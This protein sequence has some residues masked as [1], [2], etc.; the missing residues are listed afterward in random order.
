[1]AFAFVRNFVNKVRRRASQAGSARKRQHLSNQEFTAGKENRGLFPKLPFNINTLFRPMLV[2]LVILL[3]YFIAINISALM[4][5][6]TVPFPGTVKDSSSRN[7]LGDTKMTILLIGSDQTDLDHT[8][9][10]SLAIYSLDPIENKL[11]IFVVNPDLTIFQPSVGMEVNY[12]SIFNDKE[13]TGDKLKVLIN[14]VES[15]LALK[16]DRYVLIDK[17]KLA[18]FSQYLNPVKVNLSKAV[19]DADT[20]NL[21]AGKYV[22]WGKGSQTVLSSDFLEFAAS[23][24]NGRDDQLNRQQQLLEQITYN[25]V[26]FRTVFYFPKLLEE[27]KKDVYTDL[28][29][30]E[31]FFLVARITQIKSGDMLKGYTRSDFYTRV[32]TTSFYPTFSPD[33]EVMDQDLNNIF[34]DLRIF[35]E[36]A[37]VEILNASSVKGLASNR[38]RWISNIGARVIKV[39]NSYEGSE[40]TT[41]IYCSTPDK[42]PYTITELDRIFNNKAELVKKE[43]PNRHLGDIVVVLGDNY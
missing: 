12:R 11:S 16:I 43:Y 37:Q 32:N 39:G 21:P 29:K 26:S 13:I 28:S 42:F 14:S 18:S 27:L 20:A 24:S 17:S 7:W 36:Q 3:V 22:S 5:F 10:D 1:M 41:K 33:L 9:V 30:T 6:D 38:A 8:F 15:L 25:L 31:L 4:Q 2:L 35:K 40:V 19:Q 23:D 34:S